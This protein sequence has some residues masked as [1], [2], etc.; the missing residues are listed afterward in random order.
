[1]SQPKRPYRFIISGG[2]TGGHIFPAISIANALQA[3]APGTELLFVGALGRMEMER[4]P[5]AGYKIEG[6]WISGIQRSL[7]AQNLLFPFKVLSSLWK[8]IRI[9]RNFKPDAVVGVGGYASGP[10]L[11]M[12]Q[13]LGIPSFIQEQ[14]AY[15]GLTN[16]LLAGR[17]KRAY[18]AYPDMERYFKADKIQITGNP[19]REVI[20]NIPADRS[21]ALAFFGLE[22]GKPIL[23]VLG[24]SLGARTLNRS[25]VAGMPALAKNNV[26]LI[27]QTG[28]GFAKEAR[29]R[30]A[31][32]AKDGFYTSDFINRMDLAF[33]AADI[34]VSRAGAGTISELAVVGKP[35]ILVP[36]P[37]VAEDHQTKNALALSNQ[38]AAMLVR[39]E[40]AEKVLIDA[41]IDLLHDQPRQQRMSAQI[42]TFARA[43][44]AEEIA[45][46]MLAYVIETREDRS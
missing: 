14:N 13:L 46:D 32:F 25:L 12:A 17:V 35:V 7:S 6:L 16:K 18:V 29:E 42:G 11:F 27:W 39:D 33:S 31:P 3:A 19:I 41:V 45:E 28:A 26:Q 23:L 20:K 30:I 24:G 40:A 5:L 44:A 4:V 1:M 9:I 21:E 38:D 2:G 10:L 8:S 43:R 15:A 36:S 22:P 34:I 37:H